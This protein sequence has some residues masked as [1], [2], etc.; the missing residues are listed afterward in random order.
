VLRRLGHGEP[1]DDEL[2]AVAAMAARPPA[3]E[4][5]QGQEQQEEELMAAGEERELR[6]D[7]TARKEKRAREVRR[8]ERELAAARPRPGSG[9]T[10][11]RSVR[12]EPR[13]KGFCI[14]GTRPVNREKQ[15]KQ[16]HLHAT[17]LADDFWPISN[18]PLST[19]FERRNH[20]FFHLW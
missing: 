9:E 2:D 13:E 1:S 3:G 12:P 6:H 5:Q 17:G 4:G 20:M 7:A 19:V 15:I 11:R 10:K 18:T 8:L 16:T 14:P